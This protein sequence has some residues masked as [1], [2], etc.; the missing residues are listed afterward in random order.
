MRRLEAAMNLEQK[1]R[2]T[3]LTF[4]LLAIARAVFGINWLWLLK[5]YNSC[6]EK[7]VQSQS[8]W[9]CSFLY[10]WWLEW[11]VK[12]LTVTNY[13]FKLHVKARTQNTSLNLSTQVLELWANCCSLYN[14]RTWTYSWQTV[15]CPFPLNM[16]YG[17]AS[18][19][20]KAPSYKYMIIDTGAYKLDFLCFITVVSLLFT[21][22]SP[23]LK[24]YSQS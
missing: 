20:L 12:T 2:D 4:N 6:E 16:Q 21:V 9:L 1:G 13:S 3:N 24:K 18:A 23:A 11:A 17:T 15:A 5:P 8:C 14:I 10:H 19:A 22:L 7:S